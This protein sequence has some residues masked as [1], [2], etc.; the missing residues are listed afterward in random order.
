MRKPSLRI[1][2]IQ[3]EARTDDTPLT[4]EE[5]NRLVYRLYENGELAVD[6]IAELDFNLLMEDRPEGYYDLYVTAVLF[7]LE[8]PPSDEVRV[9]FFTPAAPRDFAVS[10]SELHGASVSGSVG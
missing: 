6:E 4:D 2:W 3:P 1:S 10:W 7:G 5:R 8:S 9:P